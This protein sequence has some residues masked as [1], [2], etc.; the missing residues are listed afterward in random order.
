MQFSVTKRFTAGVLAGLTI[1][2]TTPVQFEV[3]REYRECIGS[4]SYVVE[5]CEPQATALW[6]SY[7]CPWRD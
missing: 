4:G 6:A 7:S 2:E 1:T 3:G 5:A